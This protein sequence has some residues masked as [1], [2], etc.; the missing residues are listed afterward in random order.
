M[1]Q[2]RLSP[3]LIKSSRFKPPAPAA[4]PAWVIGWIGKIPQES[5]QFQAEK[6]IWQYSCWCTVWHIHAWRMT[7]IRW[8]APCEGGSLQVFL[9]SSELVRSLQPVSSTFPPVE[10]LWPEK[11]TLKKLRA[12][13]TKLTGVFFQEDRHKWQ[14]VKRDSLQSSQGLKWLRNCQ[15]SH[16]QRASCDRHVPVI[17]GGKCQS[18][19]D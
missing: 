6:L 3:S 11:K 16:I 15:D 5:L 9:H 2:R 1:G 19:K 14:L 4:T 18:T 12:K 17:I 7:V 8:V 13:C 10:D